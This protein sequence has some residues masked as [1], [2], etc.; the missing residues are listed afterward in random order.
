MKIH[1]GSYLSTAFFASYLLLGMYDDEDLK[2]AE[3][4]EEQVAEEGAL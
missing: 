4:F 2:K 3:R 1:D